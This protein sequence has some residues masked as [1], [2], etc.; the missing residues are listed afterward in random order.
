MNQEKINFDGKLASNSGQ[1][2]LESAAATVTFC[3][4]GPEY[5]GLGSTKKVS[6]NLMNIRQMEQSV[7]VATRTGKVC[8]WERF[9]RTK[10][11]GMIEVT[12]VVHQKR[13]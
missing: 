2:L 1:G 8:S 12:V 5:V 3:S 9:R 10:Y 11:R 7:E 4:S 13:N 6:A